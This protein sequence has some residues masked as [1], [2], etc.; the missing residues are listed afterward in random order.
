[1]PEANTEWPKEEKRV[2]PRKLTRAEIREALTCPICKSPGALLDDVCRH[3]GS[4]QDDSGAWIVP[5]PKA[6]TDEK[7][8]KHSAVP[9]YEEPLW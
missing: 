5:E 2:E 6:K 7:S 9:W 4:H 1:M 3:C 8:I